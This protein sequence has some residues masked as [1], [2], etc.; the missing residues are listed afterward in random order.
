MLSGG[1]YAGRS[2]EEVA[3]FDHNYCAWVMREAALPRSLKPFKTHLASRY[4]G[5]MACGRHKGRFFSEVMR[6]E[7]DYGSWV[8]SLTEPSQTFKPFIQYLEKYFCE[9]PEEPPRKKARTKEKENQGGEQQC[10]ICY[11][12]DINTVFVPCGHIL[13]CL[14]CGLRLEDAPCPV[15]RK[16]VVMVLKTYT[17]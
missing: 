15:C 3:A 12:S 17:A 9:Q 2:F 11:A 8:L 7:P 16:T 6:D 10:R 4:G 5:V 13:A 1:K 14:G